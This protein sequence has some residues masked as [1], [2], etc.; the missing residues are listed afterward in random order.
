MKGIMGEGR[1]YPRILSWC[2]SG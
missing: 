2:H 1:H